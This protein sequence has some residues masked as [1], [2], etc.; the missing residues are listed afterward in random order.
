MEKTS[1][2]V[3]GTFM[4]HQKEVSSTMDG[5][6]DQSDSF[7]LR[8]V[9][10]VQYSTRDSRCTA[11]IGTTSGKVRSHGCVNLAPMD[12]AWLFE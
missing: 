2:T 6:E 4:I 12:A 11:P 7:N 8:D 9:L 3:R 10:F 5:D 1:L